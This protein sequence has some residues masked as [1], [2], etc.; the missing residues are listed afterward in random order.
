MRDTRAAPI[1]VLAVKLLAS[2]LLNFGIA[3]LWA[4]STSVFLL[5]SGGPAYTD[6]RGRT[7]T[8]DDDCF[9]CGGGDVYTHPISIAGTSDPALYQ[10]SRSAGTSTAGNSFGYTLPVDNGRYRVTLKFADNTGSYAGANV[11]N[12][13]INGDEVLTNFDVYALAG[14]ATALDESFNISVSNGQIQ[15]V[16]T[17][18][19]GHAFVNAIGVWQIAPGKLCQNPVTSYNATTRQDYIEPPPAPSLGPAPYKLY[20][21][22]PAFSTTHLLRVTDGNTLGAG[23][24][25]ASYFTYAGNGNAFNANTTKFVVKGAGGAQQ[26]SQYYVFD[27]DTVN[28]TASVYQSGGQPFVVPF[29]QPQWSFSNPNFLYGADWNNW[30]L[31]CWRIRNSNA[32]HFLK[33]FWQELQ[34]PA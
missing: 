4:A 7:W 20:D 28:F 16:F 30:C 8:G 15:I 18:V 25:N 27:F 34:F 19:A 3:G 31:P 22:N 24:A 9:Y 21:P 11:Q 29:D 6:S 32:R 33:R 2:L 10:T 5:N 1:P 12:V 13:S 17:T 23:N 26:I 14:Q